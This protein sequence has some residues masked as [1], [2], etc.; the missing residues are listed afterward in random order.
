[1]YIVKARKWTL[2]GKTYLDFEYRGHK[3][4]EA[5]A[6]YFDAQENN[7]CSKYEP[8]CIYSAV[9]TRETAPVVTH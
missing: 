3:L 6:G 1:M 5:M 9:N 4:S 2:D 7:D 8:I